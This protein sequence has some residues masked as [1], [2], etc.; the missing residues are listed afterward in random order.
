VTS[1]TTTRLIQPFN[2]VGKF[3][4]YTPGDFLEYFSLCMIW[5]YIIKSRPRVEEV[6]RRDPFVI[7]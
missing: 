5:S 6:C 1:L 2:Q 3:Y 7:N 4:K